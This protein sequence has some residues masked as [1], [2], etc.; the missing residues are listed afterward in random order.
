MNIRTIKLT[1]VPVNT[2]EH[3]K[4]DTWKAIR[5]INY[6]ATR[7]M[8]YAYA[9]AY[10]NYCYE[11]SMGVK[12]KDMA[13]ATKGNSEQNSIYTA[14]KVFEKELSSLIRSA[15]SA[16]V[17]SDYKN[18]K[19]ELMSLK[20]NTRNYKLTSSVPIVKKAFN[21]KEEDGDH[22]MYV[23]LDSS[24]PY[25]FLIYYGRDKS[26]LRTTIEHAITDFQKLVGDGSLTVKSKNIF[27]NLP[28]KYE[29]KLTLG[30]K[31]MGLD[32]GVTVPILAAIED[33]QYKFIGDGEFIKN[34]RLSLQR[35]R[36]KLQ[37][38][39]T[40]NSSGRGRLRKMK[41]MDNYKNYEKRFFKSVNHKLSKEVIDFAISHDVKTIKLE[42]LTGIMKDED[43][44]LQNKFLGKIWTY[45]QLQEMITHKAEK[46]GIDIVVVNPKYTSQTCSCCGNVDKLAR[47]SQSSYVCTNEKCDDYGVEK[48][49]DVNAA[50]NISRKV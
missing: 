46:N 49:A 47:V 35:Q 38:S 22:Y 7:C 43:G 1:L 16:K 10:A 30:S 29:P 34:K 37:S 17:F 50:I 36:K 33:G 2:Q 4:D 42:K 31:T 11:Q 28:V 23:K 20:R 12:I 41:G 8:N 9:T 6:H 15:I 27:L 45:Y 3:T 39:M 24:K 25:K 13:L 5:D 32:M 44:S 19:K 40:T 14:T 26:G 18:D 48:N 21:I